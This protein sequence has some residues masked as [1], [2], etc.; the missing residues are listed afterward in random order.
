MLDD[1]LMRII[2]DE[3]DN[4]QNVS[5]FEL[6]KINENSKVSLNKSENSLDSLMQNFQQQEAPESTPEQF[7]SIFAQD[8]MW[9]QPPTVN[10]ITIN[11]YN[12]YQ[13]PSMV[14]HVQQ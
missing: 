13:E 12:S 9:T 1:D 5:S 4:E 6:S 11:N 10:N 7:R 3:R 2:D 14:T 8:P